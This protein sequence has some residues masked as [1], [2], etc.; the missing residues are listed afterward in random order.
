MGVMSVVNNKK[1]S[2]ISEYN[3]NHYKMYQFRVKKDDQLVINKLDSIINRSGYITSLVKNDVAP[4][5]LTIKQ[6]KQKIKPVIEKHGID[7]VYLFGSYARGEAN[8]NSDVDIYCSSGD[9]KTLINEVELIEELE[10]VLNKKV[11]IVTIGSQMHE[12]FKKQLE[13]DKIRIC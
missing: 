13:E 4:S 3:K 12:Y 11:D 2:Y 5:V 9:I 7:K 10:E 8:S 6:I 1:L